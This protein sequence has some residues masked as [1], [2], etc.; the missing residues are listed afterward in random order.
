MWPPP[1][2][3]DI[4]PESYRPENIDHGLL[5][6]T[7]AQ[8]RPIEKKKPKPAVDGID[9]GPVVSLHKSQSAARKA[10]EKVKHSRVLQLKNSRDWKVGDRA[11]G[12]T[13]ILWNSCQS[14]W[15]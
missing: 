1:I 8:G 5:I 10:A 15:S 3:T 14:R 4:E 13:D 9:C 6:C 12:R 11:N 2:R 7:D